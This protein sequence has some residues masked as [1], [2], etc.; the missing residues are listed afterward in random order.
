MSTDTVKRFLKKIITV[1][2]ESVVYH[3]GQ[4]KKAYLDKVECWKMLI[5]LW[6]LEHIELY[7]GDESGFT[8]QPYVPYAWQKK[9]AKSPYICP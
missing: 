2:D 8:M 5:T 9:R 1:G 3:E 7:F 6:L 4:D